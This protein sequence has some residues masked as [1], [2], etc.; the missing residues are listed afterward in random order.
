MKRLVLLGEGHGEVAALPLLIKRLLEGKGAADQLYVDV[1][2]IRTAASGLVKWDKAGNRAD[3]STW[4][5]RVALAG[6]RRDV[7]AILAV[8][9]GDAAQF[10]AGSGVPFCAG[11]AARLMAEAAREEGAGTRFSLSVVFA[12]TEYETWLIAGI[13]SLAGRHLA[14]GRLAV[15]ANVQFPAGDPES[16]GKRWLERQCPGYRPTRDQAALTQ[17]VDLECVRSKSLRSFRRLEH[18]LDQLVAAVKSG[19]H[20]SAPGRLFS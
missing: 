4:R 7:G 10:P 9:D 18:A 17:L 11:S 14:D 16:H 5:S 6:R 1:G 15:P 13:A 3:Y 2:I 19:D 20:V 8:Y 12:C